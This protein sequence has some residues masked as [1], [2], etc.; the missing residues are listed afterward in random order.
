MRGSQA[1]FRLGT[2]SYHPYI[3][4]HFGFDYENE[5]QFYVLVVFYFIFTPNDNID[6]LK[7]WRYNKKDF[8]HTPYL[9]G[10]L[11]H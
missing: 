8:I 5:T 6:S 7:G 1:V 4:L 9:G 10:T 11:Y 2:F 3:I